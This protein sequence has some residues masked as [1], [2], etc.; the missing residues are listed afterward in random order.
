MSSGTGLSTEL[1]EDG[2]RERQEA[3]EGGAPAREFRF[4]SAFAL[5]FSDISPIVGIY[6]VFAISIVLAGPGF[7]WALPPGRPSPTRRLNDELG[8]PPLSRLIERRDLDLLAEKEAA[9]TSAP[10]NP[11]DAGVA[12]FRAMFAAGLG[13]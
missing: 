9:N 12:E 1:A 2:E 10:S 13:S 4:S 8:I 5:A 11:R 6:S 7:F 3:L